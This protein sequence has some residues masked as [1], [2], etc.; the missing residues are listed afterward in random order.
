MNHSPC[1]KNPE[2]NI[3][4]KVSS[5]FIT[6]SNSLNFQ[7]TNYDGH[8][9]NNF[10]NELS[11]LGFSSSPSSSSSSSTEQ[12]S[13]DNNSFNINSNKK[14]SCEIKDMQTPSLLWSI[15]T[16]SSS[17]GFSSGFSSPSQSEAPIVLFNDE[18]KSNSEK[19]ESESVSVPAPRTK[20]NPK[21]PLEL[22]NLLISKQKLANFKNAS[23]NKLFENSSSRKQSKTTASTKAVNMT[24]PATPTERGNDITFFK[25]IKKVLYTV[26]LRKLDKFA[27]IETL[28]EN[29]SLDEEKS[30][31][32]NETA[33]SDKR[34]EKLE[35]PDVQHQFLKLDKPE[36]V[37]Q[38]AP[39]NLDNI[40]EIEIED[41]I[42]DPATND[43]KFMKTEN[44][45]K[46]SNYTTS[47]SFEKKSPSTIKHV[48][49]SPS[50]SAAMPTS[51]SF[52][53]ISSTS[54]S[55]SQ[56]HKYVQRPNINNNRRFD[57]RNPQKIVLDWCQQHT[58]KYQNVNITNFS[59]SWSDGLA[60]CALIHNFLPD[61][62]DYN[63][64]N[65]QNRRH[66][67]EMAFDIAYKKAGIMPLLEVDDMLS[68][69]N[70]PDDR[71]VFTYVSTIFS[72]FQARSK[73]SITTKQEPS[74]VNHSQKMYEKPK[75]NTSLSLRR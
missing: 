41:K 64:L 40:K 51:Y 34:I 11:S 43:A 10:L 23:L 4:Q 14:E 3:H 62:F 44:K 56:S 19:S 5:P 58:K 71:C 6:H 28:A 37:F 48:S 18:H 63:K 67:F 21:K 32:C 22:G 75:L 65:S 27:P 52:S 69:G 53:N 42:L 16:T 26:K 74:H 54:V 70:R 47:R 7:S 13:L 1:Q 36:K 50:W 46:K 15:S 24:P 57:P 39:K 45:T 61:S 29:E 33:L 72:R 12:L 66:N 30:V 68:M 55:R 25:S 49:S 59:S 73:N 31:E 9:N 38:E 20:Q 35:E 8:K 17:S 60:F 2:Y